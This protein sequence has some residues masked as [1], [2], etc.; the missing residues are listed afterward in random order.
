VI[1]VLVADDDAA[2]RRSFLFEGVPGAS[3][4]DRVRAVM[5]A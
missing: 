2:V 5:G 4:A 1:R 3:L